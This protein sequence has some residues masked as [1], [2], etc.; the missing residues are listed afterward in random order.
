MLL[1][2][3]LATKTNVETLGVGSAGLFYG[4]GFEQLG[5]QATA[6]AAVLVYSF[7]VTYLIGWAIDKTIGFRIDEETE[8]SGI[9]QAEHLETAYEGIG[10]GGSTLTAGA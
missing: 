6:G 9:D 8:I 4:G 2:G 7:V 3:L 1:I 10:G 5:R